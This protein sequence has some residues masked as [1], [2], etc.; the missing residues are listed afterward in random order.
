[1]PKFI[2]DFALDA[3]IRNLEIEADNVDEA[4]EKLFR[5]T[6]EEIISEGYV[7]DSDIK[8]LDVTQVE[9]DE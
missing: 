9:E 5:M 6:V 7:Q 3:W 1:M 8:N 4:K 2:M